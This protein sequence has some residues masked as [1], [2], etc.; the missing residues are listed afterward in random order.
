M[1]KERV[2]VWF[3]QDLRLHDNEALC[4]AIRQAKEIIPVYVLDERQIFGK[5]SFGFPKTGLFRLKFLLESL[6]DL[7]KSLNKLGSDL[8]IRVG[9]TEQVLISL[10]EQTKASAI[11]CNR[12]RT[13]EEVKIQDNLEK[14]LWHE[15][16]ELIYY[17]GKML[18]HT[19]D[20]PFPVTHT[21]DIFTQFRKEVERIVPI[22]NPFPTPSKLLLPISLTVDPGEI[23]T[24]DKLG[25]KDVDNKTLSGFEG[26]E[27]AALRRLNEYLWV[28]EGILTYKQTRNGLLGQNFSSRFSPWLA[29]GCI[30]PK[31]IYHEI[32][33]FEKERKSNESTYWLIFELL[34]RD[35]F[36]MLAKKYKNKIFHLKGPRDLKNTNFKE[37]MSVFQQWADGETGVPFIDANMVELNQTGFMSN[38]GRQVVAS[39]LAKELKINWL[40]GAEY[41]ESNLIDYDV[42]SNYGN[43]NYVA[44]V[45]SDPRED[46]FF[47]IQTQSIKYDADGSFVKHWLPKLKNLPAEK[48][49]AFNTLS[50]KELLEYGIELGKNYPNS[51]VS[52]PSYSKKY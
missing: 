13:D 18:Y 15:G 16:R 23:P 7:R 43:W 33:K 41:F 3:R 20:L 14:L 40:W 32:R 2:I 31:K 35:F 42:C 51:I 29:M 39:F 49:I 27:T 36:R 47:N 19:A 25:F 52:S 46:R 22:R 44:G 10:A 12:E 38:R 34:W 9:H 5:T 24:M 45:G 11:F 17:R 21:P 8:I 37:D 1:L 48:L 50:P 28:N 26:G 6:A 4:E 30:S